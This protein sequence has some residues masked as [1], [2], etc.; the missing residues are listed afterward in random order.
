MASLM[1]IAPRNEHQTAAGNAMTTLSCLSAISD[2]FC[3]GTLD[4]TVYAAYQLLLHVLC[5]DVLYCCVG[6]SY[7]MFNRSQTNTQ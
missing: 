4:Y 1:L 2:V 3:K 6:L 7:E 5:I